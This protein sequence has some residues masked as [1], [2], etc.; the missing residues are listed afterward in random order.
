MKSLLLCP[1]LAVFLVSCSSTG[2]TFVAPPLS[3]TGTAPALD[4]EGG[5]E[6]PDRDGDG[7]PQSQDCDDGNTAIHPGATEV[8]NGVDD[9]CV[10][11]IDDGAGPLWYTDADG[12]LYGGALLG[13]FCDAPGGATYVD[14]DCADDNPEIHPESTLVVDGQDSDCDGRKDWLLRVSVAVDDAGELCFND[15]F[16]GDTGMWTDGRSYEV[17]L[18]S[19]QNTVGIY[20]W[21][22]GRY[23]TAA[24]VHM[25]ISD[26]S[27]WVSDGTWRYDPEPDQDGFGKVGWC[28]PG[29]DDSEWDFAK[30]LGP[31]GDPSNPWGDAPSVFPEGSPAH[32]IW[33]HFPVDLN[34]QYLRLDFE[35]P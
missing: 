14:G 4:E 29:F 9:D 8:C 34:T 25:E 23:I 11:G 27:M 5:E 12:D 2:K 28:R 26:G 15:E 7:W 30:D 3:D 6:D 31:I 33:D 19:G 18:H 17:W 24:I 32:W 22:V 1:L 21:D 10:G 35:L 13:Q 16:I 20:G